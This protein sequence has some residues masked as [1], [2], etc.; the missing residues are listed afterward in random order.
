VLKARLLDIIIG[1]FDR[2][3]DQWRWGIIDTNDMKGR[4]YYPIPR[5]RDQAFFNPT[6]KIF[7]LIVGRE[8]PY[9]KGFRNEIARVNWLGYT[10]RDFD[11]IFLNK[12]TADQWSSNA[13]LVQK[14]LT[15][16]IVR[17]AVQKLPPEVFAISGESIINKLIS[18]RNLLMK[19]AT[20]YYNFISKKVNVIGSNQKEYFKVSQLGN[21]IEVRVY[22]KGRKGDTSYIMYTRVFDPAVT[23]EI[24]LF[25]LNDEDVFEVEENVSTP[26]KIR[27]I[28]GR[29][30]DTFN[31]KGKLRNYL[32]DLNSDSNFI[33]NSSR[34]KN[35]FSDDPPANE[36]SIL[37]YSYNYY[38]FPQLMLGYNSDDGLLVGG[39]I[40]RR[41]YGFINLPY[42]TD[43]QLTA[44]YAVNRKAWQLRYRGEFNHIAGKTDLLIKAAYHN[45]VIMNFTGLGNNTTVPDGTNFDFYRI[46][47]R[48]AE[49]EM[50]FRKRIFESLHLMAGPYY[51]HYQNNFNDNKSTILAKPRE[52]GF[53][54]A[55][56]FGKKNYAGAKFLM[57]FD[58]RNNL[59]FP[60]RGVLL[61]NELLYTFG[62]GGNSKKFTR[63]ASD[64][65]MYISR[66]NP[67][68]MVVVLGFGGSKIFSDSYEFFQ[69][70]NLGINNINQHGFRKNRFS[71][72][73]ALYASAEIRKKLFDLNTYVLP[74]EVGLM[75]F[76]DA[77]RVW[78]RNQSSGKWHGAFGGGLYFIPFNKFI[79]SASAGFSENERLLN[80][81]IG[82]RMNLVY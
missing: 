26:I 4:I 53:D 67:A 49:V 68:N 41:T 70:V 21:K 19:E 52:L 3:F 42:A 27:F 77:G 36:R 60:T 61:T 54:S 6:G 55:G 28:G 57:Q 10:A 73:S 48:S 56:I 46:K 17:T 76:Y 23:K 25:G 50:L 33:K 63:F 75:G 34:S 35:R 18:R 7:R 1:D 37:G 30:N 43:Q 45:P 14:T 44:L 65:T 5:D 31:I 51:F 20:E 39:G 78:V 29:G 72:R 22:E 69:A 24:R 71:G 80:F 38:K 11:R 12:L 66:K 47:Y 16:S 40:S 13:A 62:V 64:M 74:G 79:V 58:N 15:D 59:L 8:M 2:H 9:L 32:Y 82:T 81:N